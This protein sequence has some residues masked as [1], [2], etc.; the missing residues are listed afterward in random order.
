MQVLRAREVVWVGADASCQFAS[1]R[2]F[3]F[4]VIRVEDRPTWEGWAWVDGYELLGGPCGQAHARRT[5]YVRVAGL[6]RP[7]LADLTVDGEQRP[8]RRGAG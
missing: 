8:T 3:W 6:R 2:G 7:S 5:V 4:R 1:G